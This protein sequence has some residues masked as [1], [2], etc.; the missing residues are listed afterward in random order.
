MLLAWLLLLTLLWGL[1]DVLSLLLAKW[2]LLVLSR[3][4]LR[5]ACAEEALVC[6]FT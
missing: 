4:L 2:R 1:L 3:L 5:L 6:L